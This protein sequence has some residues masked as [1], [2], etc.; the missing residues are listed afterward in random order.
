MLPGG[1]IVQFEMRYLY[2]NRGEREL[3]IA[4]FPIKGRHGVDRVAAQRAARCHR[5]EGSR[6]CVT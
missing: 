1:K 2:P 6:S 5:A 4:Y 3:V